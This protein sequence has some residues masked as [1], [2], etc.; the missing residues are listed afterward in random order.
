MTLSEQE[1]GV[2]KN[3]DVGG[4]QRGANS[5]VS[6]LP[7]ALLL[8]ELQS[9]RKFWIGVINRQVN[10]ARAL[11]RRA[12]GWR[13]EMNDADRGRLNRAAER[14]VSAALAGKAIDDETST[15]LAADLDVIALSIE[16]GIAARKAIEKEMKRLARSLP[17]HGWAQGIRGFGDLGLAV[18][19]G[20]AGD[21]SAYPKKGHLWKRLGLAPLNGKAMSTWRTNGGLNAENWVEAG[22]NPRRRAEVFSAV[23][24]PLFKHQ[25]M[26][27][28]PYRHAYDER[29]VHTAV[30]HPDW[31]KLHSHQDA[32]RIMTKCL[33][34]DLWREWRASDA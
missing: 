21:L 6:K 30:T 3:A 12:I 2:D 4:Q 34:R 33:V 27:D 19:I 7:P 24:D 9:R 25:T 5:A 16:P 17:V 10:A 23:S 13:P 28:G 11:A 32:M 14:L 1:L 22:Y 31:T 20:E 15:V 8:A 26:A 18:I 29:R